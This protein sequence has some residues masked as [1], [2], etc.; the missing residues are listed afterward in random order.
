MG[1]VGSRFS[2]F[3]RLA[4]MLFL[5][6]VLHIIA[7]FGIHFSG[8]APG[9]VHDTGKTLQ[10]VLV[11]SKSARPHQADVLAQANLQGG[12]NT[13]LDR[14]IK[15]PLPHHA[16]AETNVEQKT[17]R[18]KQL[19]E[20]AKA[21]F[22]QLKSKHQVPPKPEQR[23]ATPEPGTA[24][25][26]TDLRSQSLE[27]VRLEAE[28]ARRQEDYQKRPRRKFVGARTQEYKF[29][30]YVEDWR[31]K[32]EK[33]GNI[34]Y[35]EAAKSQKIYGSL[36]MTVSIKRDGTLEK[37]EV[38]KSSGSPVL[39]NAAKNIVRL[40]APYA[41]FPDDIKQEVDILSITRTWTF[42][43]EDQLVAE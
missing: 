43:R 37:V 32:V 19:E 3:D 4:L 17:R 2:D 30:R 35:P 39:D 24:I 23:E 7:V 41:P 18:V 26:A 40:A 5:S 34:N 16:R 1:G 27:A 28:I 31:D 14:R 15:S 20:E 22:T 11:N 6:A 13:D 12:G 25:S 8:F 36:K 42:T 9:K 10:V 21:L 33:I 29:A 38:D